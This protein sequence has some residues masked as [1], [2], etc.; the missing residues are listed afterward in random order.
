MPRFFFHF[1]H[2]GDRLFDDVGLELPDLGSAHKYAM[3]LIR[4]ATSYFEDASAWRD[5]VIEITDDR[6]RHFL[7]V[8]FPIVVRPSFRVS[9]TVARLQASAAEV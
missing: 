8:L 2:D 9:S 6:R 7:T 5:W 3:L 4:Q 1:I